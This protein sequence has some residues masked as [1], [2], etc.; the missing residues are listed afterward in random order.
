VVSFIATTDGGSQW[1]QVGG[2]SLVGKAGVLDCASPLRCFDVGRY[3]DAERS[4]DGGHTWQPLAIGPTWEIDDISCPPTSTTCLVV[5]SSS[6]GP[7]QFG[8]LV[9]YG[10]RVSRH[11]SIPIA[12]RHVLTA[13]LSCWKAAAC[14]LVES[15]TTSSVALATSDAGVRWTVRSLPSSTVTALGLSCAG[16]ASCT[17]LA[18]AAAGLGPIVTESTTDA[19]R[20]WSTSSLGTEGADADNGSGIS[21]TTGGSCV[22][23]DGGSPVDTLYVRTRGAGAW[24]RRSLPGGLMPLTTVACPTSTECVALGAG[25]AL[26]SRDGGTTW[27]PASLPP[28]GATSIDAVACPMASACLAG[29]FTSDGAP[30]PSEEPAL[31]RSTDAGT[32][33]AP[34]PLPSVGGHSFVVAL[35]CTSSTTCLAVLPPDGAPLVT[36]ILST[37]D[38]GSTW[39]NVAT[40]DSP[41]IDAVSCGSSTDC[42]AVASSGDTFLSS[43]GGSSWAPGGHVDAFLGGIDCVSATSCLA[44]GGVWLGGTT[45][46]RR[47]VIYRSLDGGVTWSQFALPAAVGT[48]P[49]VCQGTAC[50]TVSTELYSST[51]ETSIDGGADWTALALP[52]QPVTSGVAVTPAGVWVLV[53]ADE[54]N[55]AFVS[56]SP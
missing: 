25:V 5:T 12:Q 29:G 1:S 37:A 45:F 48:G 41:T 56:T 18:V 33:W 13:R 16:P 34:L 3:G 10:A 42:V 38:A 35:T 17:V 49:L 43:D 39:Q 20:S 22:T 28:P 8:Q 46:V 36:D 51:S 52:E 40:I 54:Q 4:T 23:I 47:T 53:G 2:Y 7:I 30:T 32:T 9:G 11:R 50:E 24:S 27:T 55:G 21:C 6:K 44:S 15:G 31:Y 26:A 14:L 19:G